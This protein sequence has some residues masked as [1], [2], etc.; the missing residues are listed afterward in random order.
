M[1]RMFQ[2]PKQYLAAL[3][4]SLTLAGCGTVVSDA[5]A[6]KAALAPETLAQAQALWKDKNIVNYQVTIQQ[7]CYCLSNLVQPMRVTVVDGKV[8]EVKGLEEPVEN[9]G[10]LNTTRLTIAG[11]FEFISQAMQRNVHKLVVDYD[12]GYGFPRHIDY[13]GH[14]MIADDEYQYKLSDFEAGAG[15]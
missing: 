9:K 15:R 12:A 11:L 5:S 7:T 4:F 8:M 6:E 14:E 2:I 1:M 3:L 10:Q 13:D